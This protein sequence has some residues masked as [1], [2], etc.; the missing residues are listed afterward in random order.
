MLLCNMAGIRPGYS[1]LLC[2]SG[3]KANPNTSLLSWCLV[4]IKISVAINSVLSNLEQCSVTGLLHC[5]W[6]LEIARITGRVAEVGKLSFFSSPQCRICTICM[7]CT[8]RR[9]APYTFLMTACNISQV[10]RRQYSPARCFIQ[11]RTHFI[12]LLRTFQKRHRWR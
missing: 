6:W 8:Y 1:Y 10:K 5:L 4:F 7:N 11:R 2:I 9:S 12:L 3:C